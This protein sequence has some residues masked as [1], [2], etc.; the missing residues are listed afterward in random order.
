MWAV[1]AI[2]ARRASHIVC[3]AARERNHEVT[4]S[5]S[6]DDPVP[7][8]RVLTI[9]RTAK[10]NA[11]DIVTY[12]RLRQ[13]VQAADEDAHVRV[14]V[15]TG[16]G[17]VFTSGND[18]ADFRDH[19][20]SDEG[21][22]LLRSL[23]N[24]DKPVIAAVEGF[25]VGIGATMLLHCDLAYAGKATLFSLPFVKL[26]LSPEGASTVLLPA[27][28]GSKLAAE[29][30]LLGRKFGAP[31]AKRAGLINEIVDDGAAL[32]V[33]IDTARELLEVPPESLAVTK[34]LLRRNHGHIL[35]VIDEEADELVRLA[36]SRSAKA[37][38]GRL[39]KVRE[40][41]SGA[42]QS[43]PTRSASASATV[44]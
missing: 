3:G 2:R 28:A 31:D 18:L 5:I 11:F 16:S 41:P 29:L 26:G 35:Q 9:D 24:T 33:A 34:R 1:R 27:L 30:L 39:L 40:K 38:I 19:P 44:E 37:A 21:I 15:I 8:V 6:I 36:K 12:R 10:R 17:G 13:A 4:V 32:P 25:A 7:N 42:I 43:N 20:E 14:I 23:I 22:Q